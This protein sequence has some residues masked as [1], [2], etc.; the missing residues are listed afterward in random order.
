MRK[1]WG[2]RFSENTN[3]LVEAFTQSVHCDARLYREDIRGSIVHCEMLVKQ[4]IITPEEGEKIVQG[5]LEIEREIEEGTFQP[6]PSMEDIHMNIEARLMEKI[7]PVGGKLHTARSRNDQVVLDE[8]LYLRREIRGVVDLI[9]HF[10][11]VLVV[12]AQEHVD[13]VLPGFTHLQHAQ[14]VRLAF[15]LL[16]Y[17]EM[18]ERDKERFLDALKRVNVLPLGVGAL[19][20]TVLPIDRDWVAKK[21]GF[22]RISANAM[23]TVAD[24]DFILEFLAN[25]AITVIH[26]SRMAEELVLWS[27]PEFSFVELPDSYCTG[28]SIMPQKKN[29]DVA[30]L[31]RGKS[32]RVVGN[33]VSLLVVLKGLPLA[34]NRDLQEDKEPMFDTVD[35]L[36]TCLKVMA[37]MYE[38]ALFNVEEM[39]RRA[40]EGFTNAT[41]LADYLVRKGVPFRDAHRMVGELV[42]YCIDKGKVLEELSL[43]EMKRVAPVVEEDV[44]EVLDLQR[45]V[46]G[47]SS[48]GGTSR[49]QVEERLKI[50]EELLKEA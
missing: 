26:L 19:A 24:R 29:P 16:A 50:W 8:R 40:K 22:P 3:S 20:G 38:R 27:S 35:T 36:K 43:D 34:Y 49:K 30:E 4:G 11:K 5:L 32:G 21:L 48:L 23:D 10:Q 6:D 46:D 9:K 33:L 18:L 25:G 1:L 41:D 39:E 14:P 42:A 7:G 15:H 2:G 31:V 13:T 28:S 45:V 47:R 37:G 12:R 17:V 44:Y